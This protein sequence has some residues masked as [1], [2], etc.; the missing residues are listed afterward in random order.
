MAVVLES[1]GCVEAT[2]DRSRQALAIAILP[3]KDKSGSNIIDHGGS[4]QVLLTNR[5]AKDLRLWSDKCQFGH[6]TLSFRIVDGNGHTRMF[7]RA[8]QPPATIDIMAM[9]ET[10]PPRGTI[11]RTIELSGVLGQG[12]EWKDVPE[13][14]AG[15][16]FQLEA[17]LE[18]KPSDAAAER[19]VW[20]GRVSSKPVEAL[21]VN[22]RLSTP[23]EYL[24]AKCPQQALKIMQR[25][26]ASIA[27]TDACRRTP[28]HYAVE[29]GFLDVVRWLL[30]HGADV[31]AMAEN[32]ETPLY[33]ARDPAMVGELLRYKPDVNRRTGSRQETALRLNADMFSRYSG[34]E[35]KQQAARSKRITELLRNAGATYDIHSA[36]YLNDVAGVREIL[37]ADPDAVN[38]MRGEHV[39]PLRLAAELGRAEICKVL[40]AYHADV[41]DIDRWD[42]LP[43]LCS[44][45]EHPD[46]VKVLLDSG[47]IADMRLTRRGG[48]PILFLVGNNAT[49]LH[50]AAG[51]GAVES[52]RLLIKRK[53]PINAADS[54]GNTPLHIAAERNNANLVRLLLSL[55]ADAN[56]QNKRGMIPLALADRIGS[57]RGAYLV[58]WKHVHKK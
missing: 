9:T 51:A 5:S 56:A 18:I 38:E 17:I 39:L 36:V 10:I 53:V 44:A 1:A 23:H 3:T 54:L 22:P 46:V 11:S 50:Y 32:H 42:R 41:N 15:I 8:P 2:D 20:T 47:A 13:P 33:L 52:A 16:P 29:L 30:E 12:P 49:L 35:E 34:N 27:Q 24:S 55:G 4:F 31:N 7:S 58:L 45:L 28:L 26:P 19:S 40:I 43:V 14:N 25:D 48:G 6:E 37:K 57:N 21:F